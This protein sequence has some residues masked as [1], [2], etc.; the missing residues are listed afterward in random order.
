[1]TQSL[2]TRS[3]IALILGTFI[4]ACDQAETTSAKNASPWHVVV[5][6]NASDG[7]K[8]T[9][10]MVAAENL[11]QSQKDR[12]A[13][14]LS[15]EDGTT[16][17]YVIWRQYLGTY[18]LDVTWRVGSGEEMTELWSLST[19]NEAIFAPEPVALI[20]SMMADELFLIKTSPFDS[21]PVTLVF[22][23]AGLENEI[24]VLQESCGW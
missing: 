10:M 1:M 13:L 7:S 8:T 9:H 3:V 18:D 11:M 23:T 15:C 5:N 21:G 17:V 22:N 4:S 6:N 12:A 14:V 24:A 16:D 2:L 20:K 19:D